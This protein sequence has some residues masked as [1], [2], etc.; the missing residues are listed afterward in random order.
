M[1]IVTYYKLG[2]KDKTKIEKEI[3]KKLNISFGSEDCIYIKSDIKI[4]FIEQNGTIN[5]FKLNDIWYPTINYIRNL[6]NIENIFNIV[7]L[8]DGAKNPILRGAN[9]MA[10]GI[11]KYKEKVNNYYNTGDIVV[12]NVSNQILAVGIAVINF[13]DIKKDTN[14]VAINVKHYE[15]DEIF[16][17]KIIKR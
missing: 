2:K 16:N 8:D 1:K 17:L 3:N 10:P 12:I 14:G 15:N 6:T 13:L 9:V 11:F 7:Y 5:F 4:Y